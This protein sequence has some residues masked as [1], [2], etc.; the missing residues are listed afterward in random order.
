MSTIDGEINLIL[1]DRW[2]NEDRAM[3]R[4]SAYVRQ[5]REEAYRQG[6][7]DMAEAAKYALITST[8]EH[9]EDFGPTWRTKRIDQ[10]LSRLTGGEANQVT[11]EG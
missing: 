10:A 1:D 6:A 11:R 4:L 8:G 9:H 5:Q 2:R 7:E 3:E